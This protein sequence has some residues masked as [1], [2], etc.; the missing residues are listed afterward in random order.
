MM[1]NDDDGSRDFLGLD[2][3]NT[4]R[5]TVI[6]KLDKLVSWFFFFL[7]S[8]SMVTFWHSSSSPLHAPLHA[9]P[10]QDPTDATRQ[11]KCEVRFSQVGAPGSERRRP[12][13]IVSTS[14]DVGQG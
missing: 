11:F 14:P 2:L 10:P 13:E 7:R 4:T 9:P 12:Y 3:L 6:L 5:D 8:N 1:M